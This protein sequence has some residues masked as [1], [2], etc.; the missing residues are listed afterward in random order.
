MSETELGLQGVEGELDLPSGLLTG[1]AS[2]DELVDILGIG[3]EGLPLE[4]FAFEGLDEPFLR[5]TFDIEDRW[6]I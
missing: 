4:Q 3:G 6:P 5:H 2:L 1:I